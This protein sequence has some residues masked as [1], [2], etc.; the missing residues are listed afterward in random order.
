MLAALQDA[1]TLKVSVETG[2]DD[3]VTNANANPVR[4]IRTVYFENLTDRP[5]D[6]PTGS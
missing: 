2:I 4:P 6:S 3:V 5:A 1:I